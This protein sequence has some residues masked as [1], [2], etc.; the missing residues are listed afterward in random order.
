MED[1]VMARIF[2]GAQGYKIELTS[3]SNVSFLYVCHMERKEL[4]K[5]LEET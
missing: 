3:E 5:L 4:V 1:S 2:R